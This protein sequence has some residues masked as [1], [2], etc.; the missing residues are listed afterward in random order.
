MNKGRIDRH[1]VENAVKLLNDLLPR[2]RVAFS[3]KTTPAGMRF[4]SLD[5]R[6]RNSTS[7][8]QNIFVGA[9]KRDCY[10]ALRGMINAVSLATASDA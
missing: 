6:P 5:Y 4:Y 7:N 10:N 9:S 2:H 8:R 1:D 3:R